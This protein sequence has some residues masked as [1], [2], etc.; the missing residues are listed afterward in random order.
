MDYFPLDINIDQD[1]K[2]VVPIAKFGMQGLGIIVKIMIEI[3]RNSYFYAWGEREQHVFANRVNVDINLVNEVINECIKW[4]FFNQKLFNAFGILTSRGFQK[5][6]IEASKRRKN[7][8][9]IDIYVLVD[10]EEAVKKISNPIY[11]VNSDGN[12]VNVYINHDKSSVQVTQTPQS[13][14]KESKVYQ[15][16]KNIRVDPPD[17][18][19]HV[20]GYHSDFE[21]F[22]DEFPKR[23]RRDKAKAYDIWQRKIKTSERETLIQCTRHYA[24][25]VQAIGREGEYA[26]MPTSY[27]NAGTYKDY[28]QGAIQRDPS[29]VLT[30]EDKRGGAKPTSFADL[31]KEMENE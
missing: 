19:S 9:F 10:L 15:S 13:K 21:Q 16:N 11:V 22:W 26:K 8:T 29:A 17:G 2:L 1:D 6:Y 3:Y 12:Q 25:D 18:E 31:A 7:I 27:L 4:S 5:R 20:A 24:Q 14:V 23:R 30:Q 28:L